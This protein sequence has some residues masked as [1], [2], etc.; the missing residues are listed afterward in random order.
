MKTDKIGQT[1]SVRFYNFTEGK[2]LNRAKQDMEKKMST[3]IV[4]ILSKKI[5][6]K[7]KCAVA[8]MRQEN[9]VRVLRNDKEEVR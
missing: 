2:A 1:V 7:S 5:T 9:R 3:N 8:I 4:L 6:I